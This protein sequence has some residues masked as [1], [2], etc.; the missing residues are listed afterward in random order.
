MFCIIPSEIDIRFL[1]AVIGVCFQLAD[2]KI[3]AKNSPL[4]DRGT[5]ISG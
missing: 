1:I 5:K 4:D 2:I 3:L